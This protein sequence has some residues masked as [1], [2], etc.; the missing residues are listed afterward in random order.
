MRTSLAYRINLSFRLHYSYNF[1]CL[2]F[3]SRIIYTCIYLYEKSSYLRS[4]LIY[5]QISSSFLVSSPTL[6]S[7]VWASMATTRIRIHSLVSFFHLKFQCQLANHVTIKAFLARL[8]REI[9]LAAQRSLPHC[10]RFRWFQCS[11]PYRRRH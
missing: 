2:C 8:T 9:G 6:T 7:C 4:I 5:S 10:R 3:P 11:L 1:W